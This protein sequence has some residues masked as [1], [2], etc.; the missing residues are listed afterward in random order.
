MFRGTMPPLA[1]SDTIMRSRTK[2]I[3]VLWPWAAFSRMIFIASSAALGL[4][5][6]C[7]AVATCI[8]ICSSWF[9]RVMAAN[10]SFSAS[11]R[12]R[13]SFSHVSAISPMRSQLVWYLFTSSRTLSL[14]CFFSFITE[15]FGLKIKIFF[16][17]RRGAFLA[18][19]LAFSLYRVWTLGPPW[20][21]ADRSP[22]RGPPRRYRHRRGRPPV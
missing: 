18:P 8:F 6:R 20:P 3:S 13:C 7:S 4:A 19:A 9:S 14:F 12:S 15:T 16:A 11:V 1:T 10:S 21:H 22:A 2:V 17:R 5:R